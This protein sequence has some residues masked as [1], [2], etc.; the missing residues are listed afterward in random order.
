MSKPELSSHRNPK[1]NA[2]LALPEFISEIIHE[3]VPVGRYQRQLETTAVS[4]CGGS[5]DDLILDLLPLI[6]CRAAAGD[7]NKAIP[8]TTAWQMI[9]LAAKLYDDVED[10]EVGERNA[11]VN[12]LATGYL[13]L[14]YVALDKLKGYRISRV[15]FQRV[16]RE[17]HQA[18]LHT[19]AGQDVDLITRW[20]QK[21]LTPDDWL[22][23]ARSKSGALFAWASW[24]GALVAGAS[25]EEQDCLWKYGL[26]LGTLVQIADD[27]N[28]TWG[29]PSKSDL[30]A[31]QMS[32]PVSYAFF[33][34]NKDERDH[35]KGILQE[36]NLGNST[37]LKTEQ[38]LLTALGAQKFILAAAQTQRQ[39]AIE[40]IKCDN[41]YKQHLA[42][43]LD[44]AFPA[45]AQLSLT[46]H[47][48]NPFCT[49][50]SP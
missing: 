20:N 8:V 25:L 26:H 12:N 34:A 17:F 23:V 38:D 13:F 9:R 37:A 44:R 40:A 47:E 48:I 2:I 22:E 24:A 42:I 10:G 15:P 11:E 1:S 30:S 7:P 4:R 46:P 19:C 18:C 36:V 6:T 29:S 35:L 32:L 33:V 39:E 16:R 31:Q 41:L 28:G 45:L 3:S 50:D 14:A 21:T 5:Q 27:Y 43:L 49:A